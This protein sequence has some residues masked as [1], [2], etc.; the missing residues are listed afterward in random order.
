M[1]YTCTTLYMVPTGHKRYQYKDDS[2]S[3]S[4]RQLVAKKTYSH[5][6]E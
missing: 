5:R 2:M 3:F 6:N 4:G 1:W